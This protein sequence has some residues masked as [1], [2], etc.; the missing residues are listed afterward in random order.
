MD[1][2]F[3]NVCYVNDLAILFFF[4][5]I[6]MTDKRTR[7]SWKSELVDKTFLEACIQEL[8]SNGRE[9]SGLK[10]SSWAV[11]AEKLKTYH[12]FVVDKKQMKNRY[13]Y[14]KAKYAVWLKL[15][16]KTGNIYNPVTNSFNMT[17]EEWEAE[18]KVYIYIFFKLDYF[19]YYF[20]NI[21]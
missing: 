10:A 12:N 13:D 1:D 19:F 6:D 17:N 5:K 21:Y 9:G 14:L 16:N 8:T 7:V 11:V 15:K 18:A 3:V 4:F 20:N 2:L